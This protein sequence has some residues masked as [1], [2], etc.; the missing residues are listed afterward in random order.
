MYI[1]SFAKINFMLE[2]LG[3][4]NN[5]FHSIS[6]LMHT[7]DLHDEISINNSKILNIETSQNTIKLEEN[8]IYKTIL[9][10]KNEFSVKKWV[11][12]VIKKNIPLSAG[13]GGGSSNA[14]ATLLSL[15]KLWKLKMNDNK[16]I[17]MGALLGSDVPFFI[18]G[19][20][21]VVSGKGEII[22]PV[23]NCNFDEI[24]LIYPKNIFRSIENKTKYMY[25]RISN[26]HYTDGNFTENIINNLSKISKLNFS[27]FHNPF[28]SVLCDESREFK[29]IISYLENQNINKYFLSGAGPT[30][31]VLDFKNKIDLDNISNNFN[32]DFF[33][34]KNN[35]L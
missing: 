30:I 23:S 33:L 9:L 11:D 4:L 13:L 19:G 22:S 12:V 16:L 18:N 32:V 34:V 27:N 28:F 35:M 31:G 26:I 7:V 20:G 24:L 2:I 10:V 17:E 1:D 6:S 5:E 8:I 25:S 15:N 21:A 14:A 29:D 3:K